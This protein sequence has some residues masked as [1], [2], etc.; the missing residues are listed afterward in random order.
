[1]RT[2]FI[3]FADLFTDSRKIL[4][5]AGRLI[6][7]THAGPAIKFIQMIRFMLVVKWPFDH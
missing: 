3:K 6:T 7:N 2:T 1:M 5:S 4:P